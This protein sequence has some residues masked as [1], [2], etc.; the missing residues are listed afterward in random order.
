MVYMS[1]HYVQYDADTPDVVTETGVGNSLQ[2]FWSCVS[3]APTERLADVIL[4]H[5]TREAE[6]G[7][8]E[9]VLGIQQDVLTFEVPKTETNLSNPAQGQ[10]DVADLWMMFMLCRYS[11][12]S[13][14][15]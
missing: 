10:D 5:D 15:C 14:S 8:L 6:V 11:M 1:Y 2:D 4:V 9:V 12:A 3:G 7:Q 13:A